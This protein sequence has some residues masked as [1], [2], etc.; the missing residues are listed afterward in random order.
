MKKS[1]LLSAVC[2]SILMACGPAQEVE[3]TKAVQVAVKGGTET[4]RRAVVELMG[5]GCTGVMISPTV[6][7]TA[8]HCVDNYVPAGQVEGVTTDLD[9]RYKF[10]DGTKRCI[11]APAGALG[12]AGTPM[13]V[14]I[15][16]QNPHPHLDAASDLGLIITSTQWRGTAESDYADIYMDT[17]SAYDRLQLYGYGDNTDSGDGF[18]V[19]RTGTMEIEWYGSQHFI[20]IP[21]AAR[22]CTGDSGSPWMVYESVTPGEAHVVGIHS[23]HDGTTGACVDYEDDARATRISG[24]M[25]WIEEKLGYT[26][27]D[28]V[29]PATKRKLKRCSWA[30]P[31]CNTPIEEQWAHVLGASGSG[32]SSSWGDPATEPVNRRLRLSYDDVVGRDQPIAGSYFISHELTLSGGTTFTPYPY[33]AATNLPSIRRSGADMQL[34]GASYGGTWSDLLPAGFAGKRVPGVFNAR[35]TT[36]VKAASR[37]MAMKVEAG[38]KVY[39]SGWGSYTAPGTDLSRFQFV[40]E[41]ISEVYTGTNDY[42]YVGRLA[43]CAGVSEG[44]ID[45][46]YSR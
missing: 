35:V 26:C 4:T 13:R 42:V 15:Y 3:D 39:R 11:S 36:Y 22:D 16:G 14:V 25:A 12:C 1:N 8:A 33:V 20:M 6:I 30:P 7:L 5:A 43:G 18:G 38:G 9:V 2:C 21:R 29:S 31:S 41:N 23:N 24:K 44:D 45:A 17:M 27:A 28:R 34:G 40:G 19:L 32:W 37:Q 46:R 10:P